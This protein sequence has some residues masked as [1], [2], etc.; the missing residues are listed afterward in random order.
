VLAVTFLLVLH[1]REYVDQ[2]LSLARRRQQGYRRV[3][4]DIEDA[5]AGETLGNIIIG[6][7]WRSASWWA[8]STSY[9]WSAPRSTRS[10]WRRPRGDPV[11]TR[12]VV[13]KRAQSAADG[14]DEGPA[15]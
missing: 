5:V 15:R 11:P 1:G 12:M 10:S 3:I 8:S 9:R 7:P 4:V 14:A 13:G 2:G 6:T